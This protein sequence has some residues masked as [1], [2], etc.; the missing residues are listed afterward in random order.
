VIFNFLAFFRD[1]YLI[2][3]LIYYYNVNSG[4]HLSFIFL[5]TQLGLVSDGKYRKIVSRN[6]DQPQH[7]RIGSSCTKLPRSVTK[8]SIPGLNPEGVLYLPQKRRL[9]LQSHLLGTPSNHADIFRG[10]H[11]SNN[12]AKE[13]WSKGSNVTVAQTGK[14]FFMSLKDSLLLTC[15]GTAGSYEHNCTSFQLAIKTTQSLLLQSHRI[16]P[17][18]VLGFP[19]RSS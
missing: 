19:L 1:Y 3:A 14:S 16:A 7:N 4:R 18:P 11:R 12:W 15:T 2:K 9:Y 5:K 17:P 6:V 13:V 8:N 10:P